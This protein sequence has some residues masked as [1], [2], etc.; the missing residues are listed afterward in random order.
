MITCIKSLNGKAE[1]EFEF[2]NVDE[3]VSHFKQF[4]NTTGFGNH[5]EINAVMIT[6]DHDKRSIMIKEYNKLRGTEEAVTYSGSKSEMLEILLPAIALETE[7][8]VN[9]R[10]QKSE[11]RE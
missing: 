2:K 11:K 10:A 1:P 6:K 9:E 7:V 3:A 5:A 8:F 4:L